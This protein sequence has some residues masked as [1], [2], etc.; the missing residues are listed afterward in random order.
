[1]QF[2]VFGQQKDK[3][4]RYNQAKAKFNELQFS[5]PDSSKIYLD[6]ILA[7]KTK[8][9]DTLIGQAY[10]DY[11]VYYA[12]T[13]RDSLAL[14]LF[15]TSIEQ[16][17]KYPK[18]VAGVL[19][20]CANVY[21]N[22]GK[23]KIATKEEVIDTIAKKDFD[24]TSLIQNTCVNC[25]PNYLFRIKKGDPI[26]VIKTTNIGTLQTD[27]FYKLKKHN[28]Q[29]FAKTKSETSKMPIPDNS[30]FKG[31]VNL[32]STLSIMGLGE[33][34]LPKDVIE[35]ST[36]MEKAKDIVSVN[37]N[38]TPEKKYNKNLIKYGLIALAGLIV[39][40]L[41]SKKQVQP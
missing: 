41:V 28:G 33:Y 8:L 11:G 27:V 15:N 16:Y 12:I 7:N 39:Y 30:N 19:I 3:P 24:K 38:D 18:D 23:Y 22:A 6:Q 1:M 4:F 35:E 2:G 34:N 37:P 13:R 9:H 29:N 14:V 25:P 36:I 40:R 20:N 21:K 26:Q 17:K 31:L 32:G 5:N 10:N